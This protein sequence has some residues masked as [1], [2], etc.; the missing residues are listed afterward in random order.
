MLAITFTGVKPMET[1][2]LE[3]LAPRS[4]VRVGD[5]DVYMIK[6]IGYI[7]VGKGNQ[8]ETFT[9]I[10]EIVKESI[11]AEIKKQETTIEKAKEVIVKYS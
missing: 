5:M 2:R 1:K 9:K 7:C 11:V 6:G 3:L 10:L 8:L 4:A